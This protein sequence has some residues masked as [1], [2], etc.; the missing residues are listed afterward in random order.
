MASS[1]PA[2]LRLIVDFEWKELFWR[3]RAELEA[4]M[5]FFAF[6]HA[7]HEKALDP[8]VGI[9]AKTVFVPVDELFF[10]LPEDAQV[11]RAD[12]LAAEHFAES[13][14]VPIAARDGADARARRPGL[15]S[16]DRRRVLLRR[17]AAL[18]G[19]PPGRVTRP[20]NA[21]SPGAA[22]RHSGTR[23]SKTLSP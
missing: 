7:L 22:R 8:Y 20:R 19:A 2:L 11:A 6:G 23:K 4:R 9:V 1:S 5:R 15:A 16:R 12:A 14:A 17:R 13:R 18:S 21:T 3:R 10:M